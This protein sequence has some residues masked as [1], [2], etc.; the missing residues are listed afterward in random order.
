MTV[1]N[2]VARLQYLLE[3]GRR[4]DTT[5]N[6]REV[7]MQLLN[8]EEQDELMFKLANVMLLPKQIIKVLSDNLTPDLWQTNH[9]EAQVNGAF[10]KQ[11][12][13]GQWSTFIGNITE[14][15]MGELRLLQTIIHVKGE[16]KSIN[17]EQM[18][19]YKM[20]LMLLL[21]E[22]ISSDINKV[23]K[24]KI[25][26]YLRKVISA[27]EDYQISGCE[28]IEDAVN[29]LVGN[30]V[31]DK[32]YKGFLSDDKLGGQVIKV[33]GALADSVSISQGL[34]A[35]VGPLIGLITGASS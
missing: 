35:V 34:P 9:W 10:F 32:E 22:I 21:E 33:I 12:L 20:E 24:E 15:A 13:N 23:V 17:E 1:D 25:C 27:I 18:S 14:N 16:H 6:C 28:P 19:T 31:F 11:S 8:A 29:T 2:P 3:E 7:W 4:I 5:A 26:K 30:A